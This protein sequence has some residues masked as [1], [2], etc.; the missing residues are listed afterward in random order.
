M[1][2]KHEIGTQAKNIIESSPAEAIRLYETMWRDFNDEFNAWDGFYLLKAMRKTLITN[3]EV[4]DEIVERF[5]D[6]EKV[7]GMYS[8][9]IYDKY[10]KQA[11]K[12]TLFKNEQVIR[13]SFQIAKQ[14]D[15]HESRQ[16]PCPFT[17]SVFKL[18]DAHSENLFNARKVNEL[19]D[20]LNP[21]LLSSVPRKL[22]SE[23]RG[24][25]E[26]ASDKEQYYSL[27]TKA[28]FK[29]SDYNK[30]LE[31][32]DI[33]MNTITKYHYNND[34]WFKMRKGICYEKL[35]DSE[36]GESILN[37][38]LSTKV[39]SDKWFLYRDIAE[40]YYGQS[41]YE[42]AWIYAVNAAYYGNEPQYMI[43]LYLLQT[44][45][46]YKLNR[47]EEGALLAKLLCAIIKENNWSI[48]PEF[49]KLFTFYNINSNE[50]DA[51]EE[52]FRKAKEFWSNERY[53]GIKREKGQIIWV[54]N[55]GKKGKIKS[56]TGAIVFFAKKDFRAKVR[57]LNNVKNSTVEYFPMKDFKADIVAEDIVI[58][59]T[60][61]Q[62]NKEAELIGKRFKGKIKSVV[63]FGIFVA[64][65][66]MKDGLLHKN[67]L[68]K[69]YHRNFKELFS[70]GDMI[71]VEIIDVSTKGISLRKVV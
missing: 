19:L 8:W 56:V 62:D 47:K 48:K 2:T 65:P 16:F 34:L 31:L 14:K 24:E 36:K 29:L 40:I 22:Q 21:E 55:D 52:Y 54:H 70:V 13:K 32:C 44:R 57:N 68:P 37:E 4:L 38:L 1:P 50:I 39:G 18:A 49:S 15:Q 28:L 45:I 41:N 71:E 51:V 23:E 59:E 58:L 60:K 30:C 7:T 11:D 43:N 42:K 61:K 9:Y 27:K 3:S 53:S 17:I 20:Y 69:S 10:I 26:L 25:V 12:A 64:I 66:N 63:D 35:G 5:K 46:L 67:N 6:N 33:A